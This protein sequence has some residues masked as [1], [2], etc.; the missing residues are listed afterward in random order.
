MALGLFQGRH[1]MVGILVEAN[2]SHHEPGNRARG[3][4]EEIGLTVP[5]QGMSPNEDPPL[6]GST[7]TTQW[8]QP[9]EPSLLTHRSLGDTQH[10]NYESE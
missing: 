1:I 5:S 2:H 4:K 3:R 8:H 10:P 7:T 6:K 9:W